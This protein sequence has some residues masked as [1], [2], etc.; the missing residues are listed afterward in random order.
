MSEVSQSGRTILFVSHNLEAVARLCNRAILLKQG[1]IAKMGT[2]RECI[3]EYLATSVRQNAA[4]DGAISLVSHAGRGHHDGPVRLASVR[5]SDRD[6][7]S[8]WAIGSGQHCRIEIEYR[9]AESGKPHNVTF[10]I[11][12]SNTQNHRIA[13]CRSHDTH[14]KPI[15]VDRSG[16]IVCHIPKLPLVPGIYHL[17]LG[18]NTE[19]GISD[20]ISDAAVLEV[21]AGDFYPSSSTPP[22]THGEALFDHQWEVQNVG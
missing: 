12:F 2:P 16:V 14:V 13:S 22:P 20:G 17:N 18:C 3:D 10:A 6:G 15:R 21:G 7:R 4:G 8:A 11:T 1:H 19:A 9:L 5:V